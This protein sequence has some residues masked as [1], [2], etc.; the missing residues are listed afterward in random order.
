MAR[1]SKM[2]EF[3][4]VLNT[5]TNRVRKVFGEKKS[6]KTV[7]LVFFFGVVINIRVKLTPPARH[8]GG[9]GAGDGDDLSSPTSVYVTIF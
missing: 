8:G 2:I 1:V 3:C 7:R 4:L 9:G 5:V 6:H